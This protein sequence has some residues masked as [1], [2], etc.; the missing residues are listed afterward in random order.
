MATWIWQGGNGNWNTGADWSTGIVPSAGDPV[1]ISVA[2]SYLVT[3]NTAASAGSV[4]VSDTSATLYVQD[5][6]SPVDFTGTF[7]NAGTLNVDNVNNV[8]GFDAGGSRL[9]IGDTLANSGVVN[10]G[11]VSLSKATTVT[12]SGL[13]NT[14]TIN[15]TGGSALA[16]L[17]DTGAAPT[18]LGNINIYGDALIEFSSG[19]VTRIDSGTTFSLRDDPN[20]ISLNAGS[21]TSGTFTN[22]GTLNVD[23]VNNVFGLDAGGSRL[24][25][26][27]ELANSGVVNI[28]NV[29][30]SKATTVMASGL[31]NTGTINLAGGSAPATLDIA[32]SGSES[33]TLDINANA[34]VD[35][36]G[37]TSVFTQVAGE[38]VVTG[39]L[40]APTIAVAGGT[41]EG[42][43]AIT[44]VVTNSGGVVAGGSV[45]SSS[46]GVL[47]VTGGYRSSG[48]GSLVALLS[49]TGAGQVGAVDVTGSV[50][51]KGG[52]LNAKAVGGLSFSSGQVFTNVLTFTSGDFRGL[53]RELEAGGQTGNGV[54][55]NL[56]ANLTLGA[57]YNVSAGNITL[58]VVATP[59][60]TA[61][62]WATGVAGNWNTLA[63]WSVR[64]PTFYSEV[65][66]G[67]S[68]SEVTLSQDATI[69]SVTLSSGGEL[70][71]SGSSLTVGGAVNIQS[72]AALTLKNLNV[73]GS[74]DDDGDATI[75]RGTLDLLQPGTISATGTL[76]LAKGK[77]Y[78][79]SLTAMGG[80]T[81]SGNGTVA[82]VF[83]GAGTVTAS[84]GTLAFTGVGDVFTG[85]P[86][87]GDLALSG[88]DALN[89]GATITS[90]VLAIS[91]AGTSVSVH[92][93]LSY[94]GD[95]S[96]G[97]GTTLSIG[98]GDT[99]TL[100]GTTG[101]S[102]TVSGAG[103]LSLAGDVTT[104]A[105]GAALSISN[106]SISGVGTDVTLDENLT[107]AGS[108]SEGAGDTFVLSGGSLLLAGA[109]A[110]ARGT[111][112]G[113]NLLETEGATTVSGSTIGGTVE[114]ENTKTVVGR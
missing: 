33:G 20:L 66:I 91:G 60:T 35:L 30:L 56:G 48:T 18:T 93:N 31:S 4:T 90:A 2:G 11:N 77:V 96:Q 101:L 57:L 94:S 88:S 13:S 89:S 5:D 78:G 106:W 55:V 22:A 8:F 32:G 61:D 59:T 17:D 45:D 3:I 85:A 70:L 109:A 50:T 102:G 24:N 53:F 51:L 86:G 98:S 28:G 67:G 40:S 64:V 73:G 9:N 72:G 58:E 69:D 76:T 23:N 100:S 21:N 97:A 37:S 82:D 29:S 6:P 84:G 26:G 112:D 83:T 99:L 16:T 71:G 1:Q 87:G 114:W 110:F 43:G 25:I 10:I 42:T 108:F 111:V 75:S 52:V 104:I 54:T 41:V 38:T 62:V 49:G 39:A 65:T 81:L 107:Y 27:D 7:A 36:T 12:A 63:D 92:E 95:F 19:A 80:S 105:S 15:L 113:A 103:R 68:G 34:A 14:G 79:A 46:P 74:F 44:G 47:T